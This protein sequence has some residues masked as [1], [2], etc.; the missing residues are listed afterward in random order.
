[1]RARANR[2]QNDSD[3]AVLSSTPVCAFQQVGAAAHYESLLS[4]FST[5]IVNFQS[6]DS[7]LELEDAVHYPVPH[8]KSTWYF[9]L[10]HLV[11]DILVDDAV[12]GVSKGVVHRSA[13]R[14]VKSTE[15]ARQSLLIRLPSSARPI[16][17]SK[18]PQVNLVG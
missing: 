6:V 9:N 1:M 10:Q 17:S 12:D 3:N 18:V 16:A 14:N 7:V 15:M 5:A 11:K 2:A 13:R 8:F 4:Q